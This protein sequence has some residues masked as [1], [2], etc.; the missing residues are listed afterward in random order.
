MAEENK[1]PTYKWVRRK[2]HIPE[3]YCNYIHTSWT[4]F[5]VRLQLGQLIP[6]EEKDGFVADESAAV[7]FSWNQAKLVR[8]LMVGLV[9]SFEDANGEIKPLKLPDLSAL[10]SAEETTEP[11]SEPL[12]N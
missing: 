10:P 6:S 12:K 1:K 3:I 7:T 4:L 2:D 11:T 8:D 5:D 9:K